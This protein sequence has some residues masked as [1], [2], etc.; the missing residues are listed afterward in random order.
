MGHATTAGLD[1]L[2]QAADHVSVR[3]T[4]WLTGSLLGPTVIICLVACGIPA[5]DAAPV[6]SAASVPST[7][8]MTSAEATAPAAADSGSSM[9]DV[10]ALQVALEPL[11]PAFN[12]AADE[13]GYFTAMTEGQRAVVFA[14][15]LAGSVEN[16]GFPSWIETLGHRTPAAK[17]ALTYLGATEYPPLLDEAMRPLS[18]L[19]SI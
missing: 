2:N 17:A 8:P 16:G 9:T 6:K 4:R 7:A 13:T 5:G 3:L 12:E 19:C 1:S 15:V 18:N 10:D 14:W 11:W